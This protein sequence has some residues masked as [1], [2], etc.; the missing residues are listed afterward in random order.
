M[1][2]VASFIAAAVLFSS[3]SWAPDPAKE[4]DSRP[5]DY[6]A[7]IGHCP[8]DLD[9]DGQVR[10]P[11]LIMLLAAWGPCPFCGDGVV[12][13]SEQ[14]DPPDPEVCDKNCQSICTGNTNG[15]N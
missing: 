2:S 8:E 4:T 5:K 14:C 7:Q 11:D 15:C 12:D 13:P 1:R 10:V 9:G 6:V 3:P